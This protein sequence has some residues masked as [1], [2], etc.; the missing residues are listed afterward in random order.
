MEELGVFKQKVNISFLHSKAIKSKLQVTQS[1]LFWVTSEVT[2][3]YI[4]W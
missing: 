2:T 3:Y 1:A 4:L